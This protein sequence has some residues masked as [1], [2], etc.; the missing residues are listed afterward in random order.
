[1]SLI[2][3]GTFALGFAC[4]VLRNKLFSSQLPPAPAG[5]LPVLG[6][7]LQHPK[8]EH[9]KTYA[10]WGKRYGP[11]GLIS[12]HILGRR[13]TVVNS[14]EVAND[15][16]NKR[17]TIYSDRPF[18]VFAG[19]LMR[20]EKSIFNM[21]YTPRCK[22]YRRLMLQVLN[23]TASQA[24]WDIEE[25]AAR[26]T[27]KSILQTPGNLFQ[28]LRRNAAFVIMKV[29]YG[30]TISDYK[31]HFV[32]LSEEIVKVGSL[33]QAPGKWLVDAIPILR[34][35]PDWFP[36]A[37]FKRQAKIWGEYAYSMSLEPHQWVKNQ[38]EKGLAEP[39]FSSNLMQDG[40]GKITTDA[41]LED[42]VL[43]SAGGLYAAGAD[44][45][46]S[47][48]R[49]FLFCMLMNP[50]IQKKA[51][52]EV[53]GFV[54]EEIR[55]P[56]LKDWSQGRL[57]YLD[58]IL[59]EVLRWHPAVP[60]GLAHCP[61][62]DDIYEGYLIP[63]KTAIVG[64][65]WGMMHDEDVYPDPDVFDPDRFSGLHGRK[66]EDDPRNIVFG[67]GRRV[68]PGQHVAEASI[69]IQMAL[70]LACFD[71]EKAVDE[72]GRVVEPEIAF[73]TGQIT[74]VKPFPYKIVPR[75]AGVELLH[76]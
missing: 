11:K 30:Y 51:Q 65:V 2:V 58:N 45:T 43:W 4:L 14:K 33:A 17:S 57:P 36:G 64:N 24:Y 56:T 66:I 8:T 46:V 28:H 62:Q 71:I 53:D 22:T 76:Q 37:G 34:Y 60:T 39:S 75:P 70:M 19:E 35:L 32:E 52:A 48:V 38:M 12:F 31:D 72:Q 15:L 41:E 10:E 29:A 21:S 20:R 73:T 18:P 61:A 47:S 54:A 68:C 69:W 5:S 42:V 55:L 63:A 23:A 6:A 40:T 26:Y 50:S 49:T 13:I 1:M 59:L 27:V 7:L 9:W 25:E 16:F 3:C 67:F 44:T 74:Y